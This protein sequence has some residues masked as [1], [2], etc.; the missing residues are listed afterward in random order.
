[1]LIPG[2]INYLQTAFHATSLVT[3]SEL[4]MGNKQ[5]LRYPHSSEQK[6]KTL[7]HPRVTDKWILKPIFAA[8]ISHFYDK[9]YFMNTVW[10]G[11]RDFWHRLLSYTLQSPFFAVEMY[12][13]CEQGF[14]AGNANPFTGPALW[15]KPTSQEIGWFSLKLSTDIHHSVQWYAVSFTERQV[16]TMTSHNTSSTV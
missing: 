12:I 15:S 7:E 2:Q 10:L 6:E 14:G 1:M 11:R 5:P 4:L 3:V 13:H 8:R 9:C 16:E